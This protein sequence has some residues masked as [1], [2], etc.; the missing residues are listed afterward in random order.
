MVFAVLC[1][2]A[3]QNTGLLRLRKVLWRLK[4]IDSLLE[5]PLKN[6]LRTFSVRALN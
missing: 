5:N 2:Q 3:F 6:Y 4:L 1:S